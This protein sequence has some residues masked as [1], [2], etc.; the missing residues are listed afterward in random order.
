M[1]LPR[2]RDLVGQKPEPH[3]VLDEISA[4]NLFQSFFQ[5]G[6]ECSTHQLAS[7]RRLDIIASTKHDISAAADYSQL[8]EHSISTV[9]DGIRW[10]LIEGTA[11]IYHWDSFLPM[12][13]AARD[14]GTQVI[15]D[16]LHYGWPCGIDIWKPEFVARFASFAAAAA[17]IVKEHSGSIPFYAPIN[18]ISFMAWGGG[19]VGYLNPFARARGFELK[20]QLVRAS[21]AAMH[22]ILDVDPRARFVHCDPIINVVADSARPWEHEAAEGHRRAQFESWDM[23]CGS[24]WPQLGGQQNLLDIIGVNYYSHNQWILEGDSLAVDDSRYRPLSSLLLETFIRY[25]KPIFIAETG[26]EDDAR[27]AWLRYVCAE[28]RKAISIG[29]PLE[30]IC[31]Y[32]ILEHLGWDDSRLCRNGLLSSLPDAGRREEHVPLAEELK[33][34]KR[35]FGPYKRH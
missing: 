30:G 32:P 7:G 33:L 34:Q 20:V 31:L 23:I 14:T 6:F 9:R 1:M 5:G 13:Q 16:L 3:A 24:S 25:G 19:Q 18:E 11:G 10:H 15:W 2:R 26:I 35:L 29:V 8:S 22:A 28:A 4:P 21:I 27:P 12:L 17:G